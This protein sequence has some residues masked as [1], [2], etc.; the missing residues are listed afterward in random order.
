MRLGRQPRFASSVS[1]SVRKF[2]FVSIVLRVVVEKFVTSALF[3]IS[4]VFKLREG[5]GVVG[6]VVICT[7]TH[8]GATD[9]WFSFR[10]S[11]SSI[12]GSRVQYQADHDIDRRLGMPLD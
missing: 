11:F 2:R 10:K 5:P 1:F 9:C 8:K 12:L 4:H 6:E 3:E 7:R